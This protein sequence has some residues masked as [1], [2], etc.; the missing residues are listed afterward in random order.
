MKQKCEKISNIEAAEEIE[1][2]GLIVQAKKNV[3][4]GRNNE[5]IKKNQKSERDDK[6]CHRKMLPS[7]N[8]GENILKRSGVTKRSV[9]NGSNR[10]ERRRN[11]Q[12]TKSREQCNEKNLESTKVGCTGNNKRRDRNKQHEVENSKEQA[13]FYT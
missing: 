4:E 10:H 11:R 1:Y 13:S 3:F 7:S 9:R 12:I 5:M 6:L 2:L 8:Y